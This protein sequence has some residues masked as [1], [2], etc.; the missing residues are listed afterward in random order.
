MRKERV[1]ELEKDQGALLASMAEAVPEAL[2]NLTPKEK[3]K[4]TG[5][6]GWRSRRIRM[7]RGAQRSRPVFCT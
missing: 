6:C 7:A 2:D 5:G 3:N 1:E 4:F